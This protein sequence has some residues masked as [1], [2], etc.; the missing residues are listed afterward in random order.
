MQDDETIRELGSGNFLRLVSRGTWE[1]VHRTKDVQVAVIVAV[2][3]ARELVLVEQF[4]PSVAARVIELPAGL[5]GD[6]PGLRPESLE[7]AARRELLEE[8]GYEAHAMRHLPSGPVSPGVTSEEISFFHATGLRKVGDG[9]GTA[10]EDITVHLV[11]LSGVE[12]WLEKRSSTGTKVDMKVFA[13]L[14]F[15]QR[16]ASV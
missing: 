8:T 16:G 12:G 1:Y 14:Y 9:G 3:D 10:E 2:T 7:E 15:A 6:E 4:R 11:P 13:G 5:A